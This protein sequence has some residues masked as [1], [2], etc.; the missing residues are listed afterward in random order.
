MIKI[1]LLGCGN[2]GHILAKHADTIRVV[3]VYDI[4]PERAEEL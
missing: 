4:I 3:A 2:V 1:G